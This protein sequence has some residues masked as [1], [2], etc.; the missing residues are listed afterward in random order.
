MKLK[1]DGAWT[2]YCSR[3]SDSYVRVPR[4]YDR[5]RT[6]S[7]NRRQSLVFGHGGVRDETQ[8]PGYPG[9]G[10]RLHP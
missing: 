6:E 1:R 7:V 3:C 10:G 8:K 2:S 4:H 9:I 5:A